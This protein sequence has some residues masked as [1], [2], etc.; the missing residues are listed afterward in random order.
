MP[1]WGS[2]AGPIGRPIGRGG[3]GSAGPLEGRAALRRR[4]AAAAVAGAQRRAAAYCDAARPDA[5]TKA[6]VAS[7]RALLP[8]VEWQQ[9]QQPS[10]AR[11]FACHW[12]VLPVCAPRSMGARAGRSLCDSPAA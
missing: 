12:Q 9:W 10:C 4:A 1:E 6:A 11:F 7:S 5:G 3:G 2:V 8:V